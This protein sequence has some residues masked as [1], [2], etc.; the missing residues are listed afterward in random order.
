MMPEKKM[1]QKNQNEKL[2]PKGLECIKT[3]FYD[4]DNSK[5]TGLHRSFMSIIKKKLCEL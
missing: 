1:W 3:V 5:G 4:K 2:Q